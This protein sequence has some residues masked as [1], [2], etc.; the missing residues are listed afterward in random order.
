MYEVG[1]PILSNC[2]AIY[3]H[4]VYIL[5]IHHHP[6]SEHMAEVLRSVSEKIVIVGPSHA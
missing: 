1:C 3:L 2:H 6:A 5:S 4:M